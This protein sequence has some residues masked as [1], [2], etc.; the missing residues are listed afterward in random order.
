MALLWIHSRRVTRGEYSIPAGVTQQ[1]RRKGQSPPL[2]Y[3]WYNQTS[4]LQVHTVCSQ[5]FILQ[6]ILHRI[7]LNPLIVQLVFILGCG[8]FHLALVELCVALTR[9][10]HSSLSRSHW[11]TS[12]PSSIST[13]PLILVLSINLLSINSFLLNMSLIKILYCIHPNMDPL[14]RLLITAST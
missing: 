3:F 13:T 4:G 9:A 12:L 8:A 6:F 7:V 10:H 11:I 5:F 2:T 1:W 14:G